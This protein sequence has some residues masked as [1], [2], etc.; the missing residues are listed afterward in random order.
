[1]DEPALSRIVVEHETEWIR[2]QDNLAQGLQT[3]MEARLASLPGG[4]DGPAARK[5]RKELEQRMKKV[6]QTTVLINK[7]R[8]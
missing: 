4:K 3:S 7:G 2:I 8:D 1:M 6:G 5:V